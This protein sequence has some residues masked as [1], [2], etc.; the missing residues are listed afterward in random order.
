MTSLTNHRIRLGSRPHGEPRAENFHHDSV[1]VS[2][3]ESGQVLLRT[4]YLSLDPYVRGMMSTAKSYVAPLEVGDVVVG[5]T[6]SEV[7][8]SGA[9]GFEPGDV[10]LSFGGWQQY[11]VELATRLRKLDPQ[12]A[13]L[14]TALGVLGMPG[15]TAYAGLLAIGR[16]QPGETVA[17]AAAT[18]PVGS[19]VGQIAKLKGA[20]TIGIAGGQ[21]KVDHL[22]ELGF[23]EVIDHRGPDLDAQVKEASPE[24]ID[25]YFENVG[26]PVWD[27]V[28]PQLNEFA[29]VPVCGLAANYNATALPEGPDKTPQL[30]RAVL[31]RSLLLR[32]F[33]QREFLDPMF[34][35]F[36]TDMTQWVASGDVVYTEDITEG[37]ERAP[38]AFIGMLRGE[39]F[40]KT[41]I[42]IS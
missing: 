30:M 11:S 37:L 38:E 15:F 25:V 41:I 28:L 34:S 6:V 5:G 29:R 8:E 3:P 24:G 13:P 26:G 39:N 10:V 31:T 27:A 35:D 33:I 19:A 14:S 12:A 42:R 9:D 20:R 16:P 36:L 1:D 2:S 4:K 21:R 22:Q 17:V 40:G 23:D 7:V 18:G 32:G